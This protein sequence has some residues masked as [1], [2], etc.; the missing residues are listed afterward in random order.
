V[1]VDN[2]SLVSAIESDTLYVIQKNRPFFMS[3]VIDR[4]QRCF[5]VYA[6]YVNRH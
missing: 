1:T 5:F 6:A 3:A 4:H 2:P